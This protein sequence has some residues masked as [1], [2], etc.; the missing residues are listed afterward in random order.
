MNG[1][2][3]KKLRRIAR[4]SDLRV[5]AEFKVFV[6]KLPFPDRVRVAWKALWRAM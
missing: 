4:K 2:L 1:R 5:A 3:A 6:N